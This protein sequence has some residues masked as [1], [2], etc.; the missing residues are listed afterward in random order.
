ML[1]VPRCALL[2]IALNLLAC[3][4]PLHAAKPPPGTA[5]TVTRAGLNLAL[6]ERRPG[7]SGA[8][9]HPDGARV[10]LLLHGA[11]WSGRPDFDLQIRDYSLME[12]LA[13]AGY[14]TF[15][16]DIH[17][18][19]GSDPPREEGDYATADQAIKDVA[20]AIEYIGKLRG[21]R[22]INLFGWSWGAHVA[23]LYASE[24]PEQ[25]IRL[26]LYGF[27]PGRGKTV[28]TGMPEHLPL[29]RFKTNSYAATQSD[30]IDGEY[31][32]DVAARFGR[33]ALA[34][35]PR[36]PLGVGIDF[37]SRM[38]LFLPQQLRVPV[39]QIYGAFDL[40]PPHKRSRLAA[41]EF[42]R[43]EGRCLD[44]FNDLS[45][46]DKR[47]VVIPGGGHGVHL[48]KG[49]RLFQRAVIE[50]LNL[51]RP[52]RGRPYPAPTLPA[53]PTPAPAPDGGADG[54]GP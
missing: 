19:G 15:A 42:S 30:F 35:C 13:R 26:V 44:F 18:Y 7:G 40:Q 6:W 39:M 16:L 43:I 51:G 1:L 17:G 4:G 21:P 46:W 9:Y 29:E 8:G 27:F 2:L 34:A 23:G 24:H 54:G 25:I 47:F 12:A 20:A 37:G 49:H 3:A 52:L 14:D 48:E 32:R 10:V 33:E 22:A 36:S 31:E 28:P 11:T 5:H 38:P 53:A 45:T 41:E 50:Y